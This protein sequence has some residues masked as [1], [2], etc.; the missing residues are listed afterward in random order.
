MQK[1]T[2]A[3]FHTQTLLAVSIGAALLF[4]S[5]TTASSNHVHMHGGPFIG[6]VLCVAVDPS[7][8]ATLYT[9]AHGGGVFRS[10]DWGESWIA[11][12]QGLPNRQVFSLLLHPKQPGKLYVGTDQGIYYSTDKGSSWHP[13]ASVLE[14]RNVRFLATD[15]RDRDILYA[16]T[17]QGVFSG[18]GNQWRL[19][20]SGLS[21]KD[22]R[23]LVLSPL[24]TLFAGTFGGVYRKEKSLNKWMAVNRSLTDRR[25]RALAIESS[26]PDVLYAGTA[27]G[28]VFRT[29]NGGKTWEEFNRGLL[30]STVL[31]LIWVPFPDRALYAGTVDG[32]FMSQGGI[33]QW[34]PIGHEFDLTVAAMAFDP[35]E[36]QRLYAGSGGRLYKSADA[37]K[38]WVEIGQRINYFGPASLSTKQ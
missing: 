1:P 20:S 9:A 12:N 14:K 3:R 19:L 21:N 24:G 18:K 35:M 2:G 25:V 13:L 11:I 22:V 37:G 26:Q 23:T 4:L 10:T 8:P 27:T 7:D 31:S 38:R 30:N 17:D 32:V 36:P 34:L 5:A 15:P 29:T 33:N 6:V 28:G 16:A